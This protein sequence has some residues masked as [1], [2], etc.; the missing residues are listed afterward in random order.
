MNKGSGESSGGGKDG[1]V[2]DTTEVTNVVMAD[3][4]KGGN[5]LRK[6]KLE[7]KMNRRFLTE[8]MR[9]MGYVEG[10]ESDGLMILEVCCGSPIRRN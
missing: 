1:S 8:E 6:D 9:E 4:R 3:A 2:M 10:R 5:L 7:L